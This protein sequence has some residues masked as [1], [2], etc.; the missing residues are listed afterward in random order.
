M[1]TAAF[2]LLLRGSS[3]T[4]IN[5]WSLLLCPK[6]FPAFVFPFRGR[7]N[8]YRRFFCDQKNVKILIPVQKQHRATLSNLSPTGIEPTSSSLWTEARFYPPLFHHRKVLMT[9]P[10]INYSVPWK[11]WFSF[12]FQPPVSADVIHMFLSFLLLTIESKECFHVWR[13][14]TWPKTTEKSLTKQ[15]FINLKIP[16]DQG[17]VFLLFLFPPFLSFLSC[18]GRCLYTSLT[19]LA[20]FG[21]SKFKSQSQAQK[22]E[23]SNTLQTVQHRVGVS[24]SFS[25]T[26][27]TVSSYKLTS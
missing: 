2:S 22:P 25:T 7:K 26:A 19:G 23:A 4:C 11:H 21:L 20:R 6:S 1:C 8:D 13:R 15:T 3:L 17:G 10:S 14:H 5:E 24:F 9:S 27:N 12:N 18:R 16:S